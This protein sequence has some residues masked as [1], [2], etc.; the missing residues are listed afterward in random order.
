MASAMVTPK[1]LKRCDRSK[2]GPETKHRFVSA[3]DENGEQ[4]IA[5]WGDDK[6][7]LVIRNRLG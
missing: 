1:D 7:V 3:R 5:T 6:K 4:M 2:H